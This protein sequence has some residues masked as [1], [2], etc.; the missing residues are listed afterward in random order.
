M[1][2]ITLLRRLLMTLVC[3]LAAC[4]L[5][6]SATPPPPTPAPAS[7]P[8]LTVA[9]AQ[10]GDLYVWR[11]GDD[12]ARRVASGGVVRPYIAPDGQNIAFT[13]GPQG[14]PETLWVVDFAGNA[15]I[16]LVGRG[17]LRPFGG[18]APLVGQVGWYDAR[19]L[20]F[21]TLQA[22]DYG[23]DP[24][25]DLY[26]AN[27]RTREVALILART[28]GGQFSFSPDR[29]TIIAVYPGTYGRQ[30]GRISALDPLGQSDPRHLLFFTGVA[31]GAEYPF[32]PQ[33]HWAED[34]NLRVAIPHHDA[35]YSEGDDQGPPVTLWWLALR[36][37]EREMLGRINTS[38]FGL[39]A[40]AEDG[41]ALVFLRRAGDVTANHFEIYT[42]A[43]DGS[44]AAPYAA[45]QAG[46]L[47]PAV[48]IPGSG[49]FI[50]AQGDRGAYWLGQP[51]Q[52]PQRIPHPAE[53]ILAPPV[54]TVD[55]ALM[56]YAAQDDAGGVS[57]RAAPL[58]AAGGGIIPIA[59]VGTTVPLF[60]AVLIPGG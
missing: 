32:Y 48:W 52:P 49:R 3:T 18:G 14:S 23:V 2:F 30:D 60:D 43:V 33:I 36:G 45:G 16:E 58:D 15:E 44:D 10:A 17:T 39:P 26:R 35:I 8:G 20:Y 50:F 13:R 28:R 53:R 29:A 1:P 42:A 46:A 34:G 38:F 51:G 7:A 6:E 19:V 11:Q 5:T 37:R 25:N 56:V 12:I 4:T 27:I 55:G 40:W 24:Q 31:T 54:I 57:L 59:G 47:Q 9:W 41:S 22:F 21:N